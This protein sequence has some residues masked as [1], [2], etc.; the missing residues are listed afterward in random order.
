MT[1]IVTLLLIVLVFSAAP[2]SAQQIRF[3]TYTD[4]QHKF[5]ID[6]PDSWQIKYNKRKGGY[7]AVPTASEEK[8]S[9]DSCHGGIIFR[10]RFY[11]PGLKHLHG[12]KIRGLNWTGIYHSDA[13]GYTC[14]GDILYGAKGEYQ[15]RG[16]CQYLYF[17]NNDLTVCIRSNAISFEEAVR[18]RMIASF[19]FFK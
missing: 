16:A 1:R 6:I 17:W 2:I 18:K 10:L 14:K 3:K 9:I 7:I 8:V 12:E 4:S 11:K 5:S 13:C 15:Y 19:R